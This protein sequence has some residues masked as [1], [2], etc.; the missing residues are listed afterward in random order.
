MWDI[1][2]IR[3]RPNQ[4]DANIASLRANSGLIRRRDC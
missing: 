1:T 4:G 2:F 3:T